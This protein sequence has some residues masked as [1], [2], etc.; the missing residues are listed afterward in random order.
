MNKNTIN[1][2]DYGDFFQQRSKY[3]KGKLPRHYLDWEKK[4]VSFKEYKNAISNIK[5]HN[6]VF[7]KNIKF[8]EIVINRK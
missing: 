7:N 6:P 5:L 4:P 8:W 1:P 2:E 3:F